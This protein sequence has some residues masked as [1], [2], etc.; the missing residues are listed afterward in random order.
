[1][2]NIYDACL[3]TNFVYNYFGKFSVR[4]VGE[5]VV[6]DIKIVAERFGPHQKDKMPEI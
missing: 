2:N 4:Q 3:A 6:N 1:M 5:I